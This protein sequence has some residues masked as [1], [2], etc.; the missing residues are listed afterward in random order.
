ML[1]QNQ[2]CGETCKKQLD[3][4]FGGGNCSFI[5]CDVSNGDALKGNVQDVDFLSGEGGKLLQEEKPMYT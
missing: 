2:S 4:E 5:A 1:D 3:A